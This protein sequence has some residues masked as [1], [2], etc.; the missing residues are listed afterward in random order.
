M[1]CELSIAASVIAVATLAYSSSKTLYQTI[2]AIYDTPEILVHLKTDVETLYETIHSL[3]Q[4]LEKKDTNAAL[5]DAQKSNLREIMPTLQACHI[6]CDEFNS[7]IDRLMR[8]SKDGQTS[9][10][11]RLKLQFQEKEIG[12]FQARLASYKSTLAIALDFATLKTASENLDVT[13][14]L[15]TKIEEATTLLTGQIQGLQIGLQAILDASSESGELVQAN[16]QCQLTEA[17]QSEVLHAIEQQ[18]VALSHCYRACM[19][20]FKETTKATGHDYKYV[21][22]SKEARLLMG[23]LGNV[24]GGALH[25]FRNIEVDGGWV[26]AGNMAGESAKDFFK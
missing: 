20:V 26:V 1:A 10:R 5:S 21:K 12:G 8:R 13:K 18:T 9:W 24:E 11:D 16:P 7:K 23:D 14:G 3:Q 6:A 15:E 25:T 2:S 22:A 4:E 19:A 17:Q